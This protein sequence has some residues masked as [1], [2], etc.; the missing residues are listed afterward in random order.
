V[1]LLKLEVKVTE[2]LRE[3]GNSMGMAGV[4]IATKELVPPT[5]GTTVCTQGGCYD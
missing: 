1:T 4:P 3:S 5:Q 2:E